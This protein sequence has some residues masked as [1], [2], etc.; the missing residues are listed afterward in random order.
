MDEVK[1]KKLLTLH[2]ARKKYP[3]QDTVGKWTCGIGHN[4]TDNGLP[5][6]VIDLLYEHD[7]D[8]V[9]AD[10]TETFPWWEDMDEVR[11]MAMCDLC[12]NLGITKL[13]KF[14]NTLKYL[15]HKDY[16]KA[17]DNLMESLWYKQVKSRGKRIVYMIRSGQLPKELMV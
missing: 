12:F 1:L 10:L 8:Q 4:L 11:Q 6:H 14:K 9:K 7:M 2:E 5:E 3:Y 13:S 16:E 15:Y 17:A